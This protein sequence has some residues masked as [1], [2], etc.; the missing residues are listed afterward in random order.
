MSAINC[1]IQAFEVLPRQYKLAENEGQ[2]ATP[3]Q[4]IKVLRIPSTKNFG[5]DDEVS[6]SQLL[7]QFEAQLG[8]L[9]ISPDQ[10]RQMLLCCLGGSAFS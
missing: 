6:F 7:L 2:L 8:A 9:G 3:I 4:Q 10:N 1:P 5:S